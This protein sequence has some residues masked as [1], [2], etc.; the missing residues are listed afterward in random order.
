MSIPKHRI[1]GRSDILKVVSTILFLF[2]LVASG[3]AE[4]TTVVVY[5]KA[6]GSKFIGTQ[7]GGARVTIKDA[8]SGNILAEGMTS[9]PSGN[10]DLIMHACRKGGEPI[11]DSSAA[12]YSATLDI[13]K[14]AYLEIKANGPLSFPGAAAG[15]SVTQW[16]LP[17]KSIS[18]G[19][20]ILLELSGLI[21]N[22]RETDKEYHIPAGKKSLQI[23]VPLQITT[24]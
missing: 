6:K 24:L 18:Q 16:I 10:T 1:T 4:P 22:M 3:I 12:K 2:L 23:T 5:V 20:A 17:G 7:V 21:V 13:D 19:D 11:A 14:A 8:K 9:G 15:A